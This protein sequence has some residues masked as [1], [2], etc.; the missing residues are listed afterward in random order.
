V[1]I[2]LRPDGCAVRIANPATDR[3]AKARTSRLGGNEWLEDVIKQLGGNATACVPYFRYEHL[4][5]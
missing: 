5:A 4:A 3:K 1:W 2:V